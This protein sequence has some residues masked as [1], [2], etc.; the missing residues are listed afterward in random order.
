MSNL[1]YTGHHINSVKNNGALGESWKGDPR[2][3]VFLENPKHQIVVLCQMHIMSI[4]IRNK[5]IEE[6]RLMFPEED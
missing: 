5:V 4:F 2:N 3:I 6:V 1:G